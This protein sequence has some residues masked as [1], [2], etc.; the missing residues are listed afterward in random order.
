MKRKVEIF[1]AGCEKCQD[2]ID[3]V[4]QVACENCDV[5]V[6]EFE[7]PEGS[8]RANEIGVVSTPSVAVNGTILS[9]CAEGKACTE[10]SLRAAGVGESA[11][12]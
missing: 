11:N 9:C 4:N 5:I 2:T 1:S 8:K 10:E 3:L 12:C 6:L 7:S